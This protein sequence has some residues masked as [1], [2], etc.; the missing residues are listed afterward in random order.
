MSIFYTDNKISYAEDEDNNTIKIGLDQTPRNYLVKPEF[1]A[2]E[3]IVNSQYNINRNTNN[4]TSALANNLTEIQSVILDYTTSG[5]VTK[6]DVCEFSG[7]NMTPVSGNRVWQYD[8][9]EIGIDSTMESESIYDVVKIIGTDFI[10]IAS[11]DT[12]STD[13]G[14]IRLFNIVTKEFS[15]NTYTIS[16]GNPVEHI[17]LV[18]PKSGYLAVSYKYFYKFYVATFTIATDG[19]ISYITQSSTPDMSNYTLKVFQK[20][21][22]NTLLIGIDYAS[23]ATYFA[24]FYW[25]TTYYKYIGMQEIRWSSND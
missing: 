2:N 3:S 18:C 21:D 13:K 4:S 14:V 16:Y 23:S 20:Y 8:G 7:S 9:E 6:G 11:I 12:A 1:D 25:D 19:T 15:A 22:S 10:A 24:S 17:K 5:A